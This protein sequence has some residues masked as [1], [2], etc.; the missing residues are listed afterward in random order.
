MNLAME[1]VTLALLAFAFPIGSYLA[2]A[3]VEKRR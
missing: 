1:Y 2:E 3:T